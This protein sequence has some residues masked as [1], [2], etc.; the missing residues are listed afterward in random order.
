MWILF[1]WS[2]LLLRKLNRLTDE[3]RKIEGQ[4]ADMLSKQSIRT[5]DETA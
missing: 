1:L 2:F 3:V 5:D 4:L